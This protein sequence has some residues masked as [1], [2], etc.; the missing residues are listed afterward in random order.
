[1]NIWGF[2]LRSLLRDWRA[3]DLRIVVFAL[4][5]ATTGLVSVASFGDRLKQTLVQQGSELLGADLVVHV[6]AEPG[7]AWV[8][9]AEKLGLSHARTVA[10]RS[11]VVAGERTQLAE[12]NQ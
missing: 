7:P 2:A 9:Q 10:F 1:M 5:V 8:A 4:I 12:P 3:G 6:Q 11:V